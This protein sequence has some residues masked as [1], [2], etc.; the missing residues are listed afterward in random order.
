MKRGYAFVSQDCRGKHKSKGEYD[1]FRN[2]HLDGYDTVEWIAGQPWSDGKVGMW[3]GSALGITAHL[4]ATQAPPHLRCAYVI[5]AEGS[6]R[7]Q[8]VYIGGVYRK[9]LNDGWL[10]AQGA[11]FAIG[12]SVENPPSSPHWDWRELA[13]HYRKVEIP[14]YEVG[15]WFDI[16]TQGSID[17]FAGHQ[18]AARGLGAGNQKLV[19][20]PWAHGGLGGRLKFPDDKAA[21]FLVG[22]DVYRWFG[23]WLKGEE[24]GIDREPPVRYYVL[25]DTEDK[26]A[27]GNEWRTA[28]GWPPLAAR[29]TPYYLH[30]GGKLAG[31]PPAGEDARAAYTYDPSQPAP[32]KGGGNLLLGGK[33]P[34]DQREVGEREDYLRF[35]TEPLAAPVEVIGRVYVDLHVESDAPDTDFAAK[36]VDVYPDGYEALL[37]DGILRARYREGFDREVPLEAGQGGGAPDR[38]LVDGGGLQQGAPHRGPR[39]QL[40]RPALR[41]QPQHREADARRHARCA[42]RGTRCT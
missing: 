34:V 39:D 42:R 30:A 21:D 26:T 33:G 19:M 14:I 29:I 40:E 23:R 11:R 8:T 10:T 4:A 16:F 9:E 17:N 28:P 15:G 20:G 36:L 1:P 13:L 31:S 37:A 18:A 7:H 12:V 35:A 5:V 25:G 32:T 22:G 41:P 24:N 2:D 27:P 6:A 38:P 3:G